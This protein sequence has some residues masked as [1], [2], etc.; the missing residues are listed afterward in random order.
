[1]TCNS[2]PEGFISVWYSYATLKNFHDIGS[3]YNTIITVKVILRN[4]WLGQDIKESIDAK[5]I[6]HQLLPMRVD[7]ETGLEQVRELGFSITIVEDCT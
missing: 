6:H 7:Y 1:M 5:R 4:L 3:W 2:L